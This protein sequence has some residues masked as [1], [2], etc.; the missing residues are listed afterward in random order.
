LLNFKSQFADGY[1]FPDD[2][3]V[4]SRFASPA[5]ITIAVGLDY[6]PNDYFSLFISPATG[7]LTIVSDQDIADAGSFGVEGATYDT[8][9]NKLTN[10]ENIRYEFGAYLNAKFQ[11]D[12]TKNV[13]ILS[14]LA[15]FNNYIDENISN[16]KNIDVSWETMINIKAGKYL[17]TSIFVH[18]VYDNDIDIPTYETINGVE[19]VVGEGPKLQLKEVLGLGL[20]YKF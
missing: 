16:R 6:K 8:A 18:L 1:N 13:N 15:L 9:G 17:T 7:K 10:G 11:K 20:S 5:F 14:K 12:V 19:T 3:N 2:S 4:V